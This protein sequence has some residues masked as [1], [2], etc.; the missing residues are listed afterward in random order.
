MNIRPATRADRDEWLR[1][2]LQLYPD[3]TPDE[4]DEWLDNAE[5]GT[6]R[7]GVAVFVA[8]RGDGRL[9]G[10]IELSLRSYAEGC[11]STPVAFVE[12]WYVDSDVRRQG[13]GAELIRTAE[14]WARA[15]GLTELAS[16]TTIDNAV[17]RSAH[18]AL[19]FEEVERQICFR[20]SL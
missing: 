18:L 14:R 11:L 9:A 1:M 17:S 15:R 5:H 3:S 10:F 4:I 19:G 20:K 12:G 6:L 13:L 7:V 2:R 8:D 16:D